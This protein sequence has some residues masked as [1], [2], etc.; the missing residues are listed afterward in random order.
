MGQ[1]VVK[2][3]RRTAAGGADAGGNDEIIQLCRMMRIMSERDT[4]ATVAEVMR[5]LL[6]QAPE[7]PMGSTEVS[8]ITRLNRITCIHHLKRLEVAGVVQREGVKYRLRSANAEELVNEMRRDTLR[9]FAEM[10]T[11][12]RDIDEEFALRRRRMLYARSEERR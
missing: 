1:L 6:K 2:I 3:T 5:A 9:M 10:N 12:A 8:R 7:K 11:L 4:E